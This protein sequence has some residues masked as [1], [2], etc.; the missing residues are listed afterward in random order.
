M[1]RPAKFAEDLKECGISFA[2]GV[3]DSLLKEFCSC[4]SDTEGI[5]HVTAANEGGAVA[6]AIGRYLATAEPA[7][8]YMQNS[9][10]GN[11][12]NP[13]ISLADAEVYGIPMVL[14][15]GWRGRPGTD[16]EPQHAK[17]GKATIPLL[18]AAGIECII[19]PKEE[20]EAAAALRRA[21]DLTKEKGQPVALIVEKGTFEKSEG[22]AAT[23]APEPEM[24]REEAI[25]A[26]LNAAPEG[27]VTVST[28]GMISR[29]IYEIRERRKEPHSGD[30]LCVGGMGHASQIALAIAISRPDRNVLC[31]EGD[32]AVIMHSGSL[33]ITAS[34]A[35]G[36]FVHAILNNGAHDSVGG[37]R[38]IGLDIDLPKIA[39]GFGY[40]SALSASTMEELKE[41]L[42][43]ARSLQRPILI[44]ARVRKGA[45]KNLG[46]PPRDMHEAKRAAME[47]MNAQ[48][49]LG[50]EGRSNGAEP[51]LL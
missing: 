28:T 23:P 39:E 43:K 11:A 2:A 48:S 46:R 9:G 40:K 34:K 38:T 25:E 19:L 12:L 3:P 44:E 16:D 13:L 10:I 22:T 14:L 15:V 6:L 31:I 1:T 51:C 7:L 17:Q 21:V 45:R 29:E 47:Y 20:E 35:P 8:V 18:E 32:G 24:G 4:I 5:T 27:T 50:L 36:N 37:Q 41:I 26:I 42:R 49:A 33:G 30:F